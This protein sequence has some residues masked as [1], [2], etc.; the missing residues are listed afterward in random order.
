MR[1]AL[2]AERD[3]AAGDRLGILHMR[4]VGAGGI[5]HKHKMPGIAVQ[6]PHA[7]IQSVGVRVEHRPL[8]R[9]LALLAQPAHAEQRRPAGQTRR[10][11]IPLERDN[12]IDLVFPF[13]E[14]IEGLIVDG[15]EFCGAKNP[16]RAERIP[17][18]RLD[19]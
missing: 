12:V 2:R 15:V 3:Y 18:P 16:A 6:R 10:G 17:S 14:A 1:A 9:E 4:D 7:G 5:C 11:A 13:G 8:P 19:R